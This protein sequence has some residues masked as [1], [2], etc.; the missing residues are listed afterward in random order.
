MNKLWDYKDYVKH[1]K[2]PNKLLRR[3]AFQALEECFPN[4]YADEVADLIGDEDSHLACTAPRYLAKHGAVQ[5]AEKIMACFQEKRDNVASNCA[6]ALGIM[7]YE[8]AVDQMLEY[9]SAA[10]SAETFLG[11]LDYLGNIKRENC[12]EALR[13][14]VQ[15]LQDSFLL[16]TA[17]HNLLLHY[18]VKDIP[19]VLERYFEVGLEDYYSDSFLRTITSTLGGDGYFRDLTENS[20]HNIVEKPEE[21]INL[22]ISRNPSVAIPKDTRKSIVT[23]LSN[24]AFKDLATM[25]MFNIRTIIHKRYPDE[26]TPDWLVDTYNQDAV[27]LTLL[28]EISKQSSIW[29]EVNNTDYAERNLVALV[30]AVFF[31]VV[32]REAYV[33]ALSPE[34]PLDGLIHALINT[35]S[36]F[37]E[38]IQKKIKEKQP[39]TELKAALTEELMTWGDI[40]IVRMMKQIGSAEFVHEL[41]R[42]LNKSDSL[43]YIYGDAL[44]AM[45]SLDKSSHELIISSIKKKEIGDWQSFALLEHLPYSEAYDLAIELWNDENNEMDSYEIFACCLEGI[46]DPRGIKKL[47]HI[48][49]YENDATYIG[50]SL[51]CL[52]ALHGITLPELPKIQ[53]QRQKSEE[54]RKAREKEFNKLASDYNRQKD[55][56]NLSSPGQVI[57]FKREE[58]KTGR[59]EPCPC[60]SGKK[61]KKC[62]LRKK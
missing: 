16:Q 22:F 38:A 43:D 5:H 14:A 36:D 56:E 53:R 21:V 48:Y 18:H 2:H 61:Y 51:E 1:L 35:G 13:T 31:A 55:K 27:C 40:W 9:F 30:L 20:Q 58:P 47:R 37:P 50:E 57:P 4:R 8:S 19:L 41:I 59:N 46:G 44:N 24:K 7:G 26:V 23:S 3:W 45:Y 54:R 11:I 12:R 25:I 33:K 29:K 52:A 10:N 60:G 39:V 34:T 15:Q 17:A 28:E 6:F 49:N 62:C 32:E 42:V